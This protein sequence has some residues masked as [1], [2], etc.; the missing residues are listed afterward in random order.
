M[1][2]KNTKK[3]KQRQQDKLL[4]SAELCAFLNITYDQAR[5]LY[6]QP[7]FPII[8]LNRRIY[9]LESSLLRWLKEKE[10]SQADDGDCLCAMKAG[11]NC[12]VKAH[13]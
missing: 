5:T 3:Q 10:N 2:I 4:S 8:R 1:T 9:V 7:G 13:K 12:C 6:S 11:K